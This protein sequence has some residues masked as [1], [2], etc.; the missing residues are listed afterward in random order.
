MTGF[1]VTDDVIRH[2]AGLTNPHMKA[3][4]EDVTEA[5]PEQPDMAF[6]LALGFSVSALLNAL[7][8]P[9]ERANAVDGINLLVRHCGYA[10]TPVT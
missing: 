3:L 10:L 6:T 2:I 9:V 8:D 1:T 7:S 4:N 5:Y